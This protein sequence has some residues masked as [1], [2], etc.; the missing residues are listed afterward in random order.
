MGLRQPEL[1]D[2]ILRG[3]ALGQRGFLILQHIAEVELHRLD[4]AVAGELA[5]HRVGRAS[6]NDAEQADGA[7]DKR[8]ILRRKPLQAM[9]PRQFIGLRVRQGAVDFGNEFVPDRAQVDRRLRP[10]AARTATAFFGRNGAAAAIGRDHGTVKAFA[11][12]TAIGIL[13]SR[14]EIMRVTRIG[15]RQHTDASDR[16][17]RRSHHR[18]RDANARWR[19]SCDGG[20]REIG[21]TYGNVCPARDVRIDPGCNRRIDRG[22]PRADVEVGRAH[23]TLRVNGRTTERG[24]RQNCGRHCQCQAL[25]PRPPIHAI[26][27]H[28]TSAYA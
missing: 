16:P 1:R 26:V 4:A 5:L 28:G 12:G 9:T 21:P 3:I 11:V 14:I 23:D 20:D 17:G 18:G 19:G 6:I 25:R 7:S 2:G 24:E 27:G 13:A 15:K 22:Q 10:V 8:K